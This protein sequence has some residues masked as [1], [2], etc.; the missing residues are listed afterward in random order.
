MIDRIM[1]P[2]ALGTESLFAK[3]ISVESQQLGLSL[4]HSPEVALQ[5]TPRETCCLRGSPTLDT[6]STS[7]PLPFA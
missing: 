6:L 3:T 5:E 2:Q 4:G 7:S 1:A